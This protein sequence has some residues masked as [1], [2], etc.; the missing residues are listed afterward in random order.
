MVAA[1]PTRPALLAAAFALAARGVPVMPMHRL[2][3][4]RCSCRQATECGSA[5]KHPVHPWKADPGSRPTTAADKIAKWWS[6]QA[7]NIG[8]EVPAG[9]LV[10]DTDA[11]N[12][13]P[14]LLEELAAGRP[15]EAWADY[16]GTDVGR[17]YWLRL[18]AGYAGPTPGKLKGGGDLEVDLLWAGRAVMMPPSTHRAG[19]LR[20]WLEQSLGDPPE[21]PTWLLEAIAAYAGSERRAVGDGLTTPLPPEA[22][23]LLEELG[24]RM[25]D[26]QAIVAACGG[27]WQRGG[28]EAAIR[29]PAH[30]DSHPS[31]K[32]T[33]APNGRVLWHC[34]AG[35]SQGAMT[36]AIRALPGALLPRPERKPL[37]VQVRKPGRVYRHRT[38][39]RDVFAEALERVEYSTLPAN[40]PGSDWHA[41]HGAEYGPADRPALWAAAVREC[42]RYARGARADCDEG[43]GRV[44]FAG[45]IP[46]RFKL[47]PVCST[48]RLMTKAHEHDSGWKLAG[49]ETFDVYR[50]EGRRHAGRG[51]FR[52]LNAAFTKWRSRRD[53]AGLTGASVL[54]VVVLSEDGV[55]CIPSLLLAVPAG[56]V[57][58]GWGEGRTELLAEGAGFD[59]VHEAQIAAWGATL[60]QVAGTATLEHLLEVYSPGTRVLEPIGT[61]R[62]AAARAE[63]AAAE[64]EGVTVTEHRKAQKAPQG[65]PCPFTTERPHHHHLLLERFR[66]EEGHDVGGIWVFKDRDEPR[67]DLP[68]PR[69]PRQFAFA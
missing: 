66:Y 6:A 46:C 58:A 11:R 12:G 47:C 24:P 64:E 5:G 25:Y 53:G 65:A 34:Y 16:N 44:Y 48:G 37:E 40:P 63:R 23:A 21:A 19:G 56:T 45:Y 50:L 55:T 3:A 10:V 52:E 18:P 4:G 43:G 49:V 31:A 57:L 32:L 13:G 62:K 20:T 60:D 1:P 8:A 68:P 69:H 17:H 27:E 61:P 15:L 9:W 33:I 54:R 36:A 29:C 35:C 30:D 39:L 14:E 26:P 59:E 22:A 67:A 51:G 42:M 38:D 2:E 41:E 7:W 28:L